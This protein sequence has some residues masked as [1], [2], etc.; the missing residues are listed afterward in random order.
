MPLARN[1]DSAAKRSS[2]ELRLGGRKDPV[3]KPGFSSVRRK[4]S[5]MSRLWD[6]VQG[7]QHLDPDEMLAALN[8]EKQLFGADL[9][10]EPID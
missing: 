8:Q 1:E 5:G 7:H 9:P 4:C 2:L 3:N 6:F 10:T